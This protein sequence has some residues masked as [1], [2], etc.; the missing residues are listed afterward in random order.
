M[1]KEDAGCPGFQGKSTRESS[2][3]FPSDLIQGCRAG[4]KEQLGTLKKMSES[5]SR[6]SGATCCVHVVSTATRLCTASS[7]WPRAARGQ[8]ARWRRLNSHCHPG[9]LS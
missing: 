2:G 6:D 5:L 3:S 1:G 8:C 9:G 7:H 4:L